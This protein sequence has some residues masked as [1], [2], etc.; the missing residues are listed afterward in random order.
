MSALLGKVSNIALA[1]PSSLYATLPIK[2]GQCRIFKQ[3]DST[4]VRGTALLETAGAVFLPAL[5]VCGSNI[6]LANNNLTPYSN[7]P[8][9]WR[10]GRISFG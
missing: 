6:T 4:W 10:R 5:I 7:V 3:N 1:L 8:T 2:H 9:F